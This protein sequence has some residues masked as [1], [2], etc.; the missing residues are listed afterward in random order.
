MNRTAK[1]V[2]W[3]GI[4]LMFS[5]LTLMI[6]P[7]Q[8]MIFFWNN[9]V[10]DFW[11]RT[12]GYFMAFEGFICYKAAKDDWSPFFNWIKNIR[13]LQSFFF[14]AIVLNDFANPG[15]LFYST[16]EIFFGIWTFMVYAQDY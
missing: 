9:L 14:L 10:Y 3:S 16:I 1:S 5:G 11:L 6:I 8:V 13:V 15:L 4:V 7:E 2:Y 12:L